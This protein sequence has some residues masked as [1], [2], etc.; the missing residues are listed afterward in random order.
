MSGLK[1]GDWVKHPKIEAALYVVDV[2]DGDLLRLRA[3]SPD[4]WP[5]PVTMIMPRK[6][7]KLARPPKQ[8]DDFEE[9]PW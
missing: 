2:L 1:Q 5:Y 3:P 6:D 4:G 7:V 8:E 9:A